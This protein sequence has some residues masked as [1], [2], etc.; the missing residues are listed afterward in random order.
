MG[1]NQMILNKINLECMSVQV[2]GCLGQQ[3]AGKG[4]ERQVVLYLPE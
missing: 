4:E 3:G 2:G 1:G